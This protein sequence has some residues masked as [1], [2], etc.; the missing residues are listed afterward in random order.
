MLGFFIGYF[1][2]ENQ[3]FMHSR[4]LDLRDKVMRAEQNDT[5]TKIAQPIFLG[6]LVEYYSPDQNTVKPTEA[7]LYAGAVVLCSA[8][9]V[10]VVHPYMMAILHMGMK[11]R[12]ACCSLIYRKSLRL[13]KTALGE[14][15]VGQVVNLLSND[16]N[17]FDVAVIFIHYLWIGPLATVIITFFM[18]C[19]IRWA[20]V[21]GVGFMLA[22]IP[23]QA[24]LGK[25][26]SVLRLKTALRT[27]ERVRLMNEILSGIQVIKMYTW[28]KPFADLVAKARKQEIKQIRATSYIRGVL[29]S[30]IM[31]TTRICLFCS[32]LAYVLENNV[33]SAKQVFVVTSFYNILRQTMTVFFP[34]GIAQ[35]AEATISIKRLQSFMLY[36][37]TSKPVPGL[38]EIIT[39]AKRK[40]KKVKEEKDLKEEKRESATSVK[41]VLE[42]KDD[43]LQDDQDIKNDDFVQA[44]D[45]NAPLELGEED[46]EEIGTR[47]EEDARGV[48]LK[49]ATAKWIISHSENTLTDLSLTI[50]PGKLIAVIG[51]VGA[52]KSSL[53]HV[54]LK[55]LPLQSG[56][57]HIGGT[58]SYASQEPWLF[59]GSVRQNILFGQPMDRPR[60]NTVVR[61]CALDRDFALLPH[62]DKTVVGE[63]GVSLSGGTAAHTYIHSVKIYHNYKVERY[64]H[65]V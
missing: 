42:S 43:V 28:E 51:P 56:S 39:S 53:L 19:E 52:G 54:L 33:I 1:G 30:F 16:V 45:K 21:V 37:D 41:D 40:G 23:L 11:F 46:D 32:I 48:R 5:L 57:V 2:Q 12:V 3:L 38:A 7:Y 62:G 31:F 6:W 34:Q 64:N 60:Y 35:V 47:V 50:K 36:E 44:N 58:I 8:L 17:R 14:T 26:T 25:R 20:A 27:D 29:T 61:R 24:Y 10:F 9:N 63:R 15:T 13:S 4:L 49:H 22:F 59:A 55:E 65:G 18:W